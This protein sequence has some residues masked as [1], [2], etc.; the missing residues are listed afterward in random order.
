MAKYQGHISNA[1]VALM[2][3]IAISAILYQMVG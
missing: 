1:F 2:G 3:T